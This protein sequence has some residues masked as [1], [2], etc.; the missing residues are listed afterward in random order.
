MKAQWVG[1]YFSQYG[2]DIA[3]CVVLSCCLL[4][5][6]A[7]T[8]RTPMQQ[9]QLKQQ[10][11]AIMEGRY[12]PGMLPRSTFVALKSSRRGP[13]TEAMH[14]CICH[15]WHCEFWQWHLNRR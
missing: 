13:A 10:Q 5:C 9:Q 12:R 8:I 15:S 14:A 7:G 6:V 3:D 4:V 1:E 11:A 2:I